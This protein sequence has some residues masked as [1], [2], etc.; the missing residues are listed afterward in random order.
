MLDAAYLQ[1]ALLT[2]VKGGHL[3]SAEQLV[4]KG[5]KGV[6]EGLEM[7]MKEGNYTMCVFLLLVQA[8]AKNDI[9][10]FK[11]LFGPSAKKSPLKE[12]STDQF[13]QL[14]CAWAEGQVP[15]AV[16][17]ELASRLGHAAICE[18]LL[19]RRGVDRE[20]GAVLWQGCHLMSLHVLYL[21]KVSWVK[22]LVLARNSIMSMPS[23]VEQY[24]KKVCDH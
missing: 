6:N 14:Q 5:A 23:E 21:M 4:S 3:A 9:R 24:L 10:L 20:A 22:K 7:A 15:T 8:A 11:K 1:R 12:Y 13:R 18:Q 17:I 16:P 19:T 2:A